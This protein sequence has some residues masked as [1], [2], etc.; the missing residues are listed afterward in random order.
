MQGDKKNLNYDELSFL[1]NINNIYG[2]THDKLLDL[3]LKVD[4]ITSINLYFHMLALLINLE[5][6]GDELK[7]AYLSNLISFYIFDVITPPYSE[8]ISK[9]YAKK[10]LKNNL[11]PEYIEWFEYINRGN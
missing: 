11:A 5:E 10:S 7:I 9:F 8:E 1:I 4:E 3:S 2:I 6:Q